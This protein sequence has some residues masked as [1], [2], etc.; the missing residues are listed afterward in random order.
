MREHHP[1]GAPGLEIVNG[2]DHRDAALFERAEERGREVAARR[3]D[4]GDVGPD[5][6]QQAGHRARGGRRPDRV[7][8]L[9]EAASGR[10]P[11]PELGRR[12]EVAGG[13]A[14]QVARIAGREVRDLVPGL[15][16]PA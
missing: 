4:V 10:G 2:H 6:T 8:E 16:Q 9:G 1:V 3:V 5:L 14:G 12:R 13:G 15:A 11:F 7:R